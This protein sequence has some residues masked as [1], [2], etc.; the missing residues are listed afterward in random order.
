MPRPTPLCAPVMTSRLR[1][2]AAEDLAESFKALADPARLLVLSFLAGQRSGEACVC[3][4]TET[5]GLSQ[6]TVSHH[7]GRLLAAGLL[8]REKRGA[9]AYYRIVPAKL[10]ELRAALQP[11]EPER[12]VARRRRA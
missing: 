4:L 8:Q 11:R 9:W 6:P 12:K 7:L 2:A 5:L 1:R 10:E 3:H